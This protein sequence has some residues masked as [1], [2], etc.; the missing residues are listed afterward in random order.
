MTKEQCDK[1][2]EQNSAFYKKEEEVEGYKVFIY[3]Y[4]L[5]SYKD[6]RD[7]NAFEMRGLTFI[8]NPDTKKYEKNLA[9]QKFFNLNENESSMLDVV[10]NKKII[11]IMDKIDGSLITFVRLPNGSIRAKTKGT[12]Y[13]EQAKMAQ[14]YFINADHYFRKF[15]TDCLNTGLT[16]VFELVSPLN[17]IVISYPKTELI[18]LQI[19]DKEGNYK[20]SDY[21]NSMSVNYNIKRS[22]IYNL[23]E[24][25]DI[26]SEVLSRQKNDKG[27]EGFVISLEDGQM[28]KVKTEWYFN[29]HSILSPDVLRENKIIELTLN[30]EIDD[31]VSQVTSAEKRDRINSIVEN[32]ISIY[33]E[34]VDGSLNGLKTLRDV[35]NWDRKAF[36]IDNKKHPLFGVVMKLTNS[37]DPERDARFFVKNYILKKT[38]TYQNALNFLGERS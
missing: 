31:I 23:E 9:L 26:W 27:Y 38:R 11:R 36:A 33:D 2:C 6:F 20:D 8:Y 10:K 15:I 34:M 28:I 37:E 12:F 35:Y 30:E 24:Y 21:I 18:L 19:R 17:E 14:E 7:F 29:M 32:T 22:K 13:S 25:D 5:A 1:I 16:P 3:N 4:R